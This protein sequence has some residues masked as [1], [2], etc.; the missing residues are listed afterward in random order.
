MYYK[1]TDQMMRT[2]QDFQWKVGKWERIP[3]E[4]R[5]YDLCTESWFH[6]YNHPF[7]AVILNPVHAEI[8]NP[9]LFKVNVAGRKTSDNGLKFGFSMMRLV[10]ELP[11]PE[12]TITQKI[13]FG[14]LCVKHAYKHEQ[15]NKWAD[16]WLSDKDR[17]LTAALNVYRVLEAIDK[18]GFSPDFSS[19]IRAAVNITNA[20]TDYDFTRD[21]VVRDVDVTIARAVYR[22]VIASNSFWLQ[23]DIN[24]IKLA[25]KAMEY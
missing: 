8:V 1:I 22:A 24:L 25:K 15:W 10:E 17:S 19:S 7:L 5:G 3:D 9:R 13:A 11:L 14:I 23:A 2:Y 16:N 18:N 20:T 6:C 12:I 21:V 4:D